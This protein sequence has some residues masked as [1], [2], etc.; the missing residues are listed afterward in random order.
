M[1]HEKSFDTDVLIRSILSVAYFD[2]AYRLI[3]R[4]AQEVNHVNDDEC[5]RRSEMCDLC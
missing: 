1:T 4:L 2:K 5:R 3:E